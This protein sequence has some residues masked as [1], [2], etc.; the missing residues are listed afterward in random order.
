MLAAGHYG[1]TDV[2]PRVL[3]VATKFVCIRFVPIVPLGSYVIAWDDDKAERA[4]RVKL[5]WRSIFVAWLRTV[6]MVGSLFAVV[7]FGYLLLTGTTQLASVWL[8]AAAFLGIKCF[9][10]TYRSNRLQ[11]PSYERAVELG[12]T[13]GINELGWLQ[14]GVRY[15]ELSTREARQRLDELI[16][17]GKDLGLPPEKLQDPSLFANL[18]SANP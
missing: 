5:N 3:Y 6:L 15:G 16:A 9:R 17:S 10:A 12:R 7:Y 1:R 2:V 18:N 14:L 4:V 11:T 8:P 13:L